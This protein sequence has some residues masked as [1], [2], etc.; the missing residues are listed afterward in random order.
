LG[1]WLAHFDGQGLLLGITE[2]SELFLYALIM[3]RDPDGVQLGVTC[4]DRPMGPRPRTTWSI[5][6]GSPD[7]LVREPAARMFNRGMEQIRP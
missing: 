5:P 7:A 2:R 3:A 4:H 6:R 1:R